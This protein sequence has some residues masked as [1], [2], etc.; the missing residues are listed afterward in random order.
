MDRIASAH[1]TLILSRAEVAALAGPAD[2]LAAMETA[3][4]ALAA[5]TWRAAAVG[6]IP[7]FN[8]A[9]HIKSAL[10]CDLPAVVAIK[11]NGNFPNNAA[12]AGL[13]TIQGC[14]LLADANDGRVLALMDSIEITAR[15]TAAATAL[16]ARHLARKDATVLAMVGCGVQARHHLE[17][18]LALPDFAFST[19]RLF[20]PR[21]EASAALA[22]AGKNAGLSVMVAATAAAAAHSAQIVVLTTT[23]TESLLHAQDV[24]PGMFIAAVGA[25]SPS[26]SELSPALMARARV[27]PDV[28]AQ[29][30]EMGDLRLA[31]AAGAMS[32]IDIHGELAEVV[33]GGIPGRQNDEQIFV[34]DSTGTAI[35][36]VAAASMLYGL[37]RERGAGLSID[38]NGI[39][40][41]SDD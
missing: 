28:L 15:R 7:A 5:G 6:H 25:D 31:I 26:K 35:E 8:G 13:P 9:F 11:I 3:F 32:I 27:V 2:Y 20:D 36:D 24:Q 29:A 34:F 21:T 1:S 23:S 4:K 33:A 16:A 19:L 18:M 37:A 38:F 14:L 22:R 12:R 41:N 10:A 40:S 30:A 39:R 17:A